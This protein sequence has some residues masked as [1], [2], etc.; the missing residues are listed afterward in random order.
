MMKLLVLAD[1]HVR[2][3]SELPA[4]VIRAA[5]ECDWLVHCGDYTGAAVIDELRAL[6]KRFSGVYGNSDPGPVRVRLPHKLTLEVDGCRLAV[7]HPEWGGFPDGIEAELLKRFA[8]DHDAI[9]FGHTHEPLLQR[10]GETL[11]VNPGQAYHSFMV[12]ATMV[13]LTVSGGGVE[14]EVVTVP[15]PS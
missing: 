11:L 9:L 7:V 13:R 10:C 4:E 2:S 5:R 12:P 15:P 8:A 6:A 14:G 1:T 3:V